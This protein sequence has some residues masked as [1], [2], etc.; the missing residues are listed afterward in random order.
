M[1]SFNFS[2]V[3]CVLPVHCL[4]TT[5]VPSMRPTS[6]K[7]W[8]IRLNSVELSSFLASESW[9]RIFNL[10]S[11]STNMRKYWDTNCIWSGTMHPVISFDPFQ[12]NSW[13]D[14]AVSSLPQLTCLACTWH[15]EKSS[16][17]ISYTGVLLEPWEYQTLSDKRSGFMHGSWLLWATALGYDNS[18]L[19]CW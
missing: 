19:Q 4:P 2:F 16:K 1:Y 10:K 17:C 12:R 7:H 8:P 9:V 5:L 6:W 15:Q 3:R 18:D 11:G 13:C 14:W